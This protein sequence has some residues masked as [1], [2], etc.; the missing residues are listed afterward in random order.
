MLRIG[1]ART[2][3]LINERFDGNRPD[4][5]EEAILDYD[6][7]IKIME[8]DFRSNPA[9]ALYS[10]YPDALV[11]R[12]L[13]KEGLA[14]WEGAVDDYSKAIA[15]WRP[16]TPRADIPLRGSARP[17]EGDGL[18]VNPLVLNF[19]ANALCQLNRYNE[20]LSDYQEA[21]DIF[22]NDGEYR[23]AQISRANEALA[24]YGAGEEEDAVK[25]MESVIKKDQGITDMHVAL[26]A[27]Y[28]ER[29]E[30]AKAENRWSFACENIDSGCGAYKDMKWVR[31][32]RRWP[33]NL[34]DKLQRFLDHDSSKN[35][36]I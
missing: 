36:K 4:K 12:A 8:D 33:A 31:G 23:Q 7:A 30:A 19:R 27:V 17:Q 1:R 5:A 26:A 35:V 20:A 28:W 29:G 13:V 6:A 11:R 2:K 3:M 14:K 9:K 16:A 25:R 24:L 18:G 22:I 32:I 15:L 10:E 34:A 21:T